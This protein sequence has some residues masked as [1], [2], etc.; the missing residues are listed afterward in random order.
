MTWKPSVQSWLTPVCLGWVISVS[1][2]NGWGQDLLTLGASA[3]LLGRALVAYQAATRQ[4]SEGS[5]E[6]PP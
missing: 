1:L 2:Q 3:Y 4:R 6:G 5:E